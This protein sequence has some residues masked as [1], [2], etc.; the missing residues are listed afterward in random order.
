MNI[1]VVIFCFDRPEKLRRTLQT[2]EKNSNLNEYSFIAYQDGFKFPQVT[3]AY[4][5]VSEVWKQFVD[6]NELEFSA[7]HQATVNKGMR[8][9]IFE[10][11][12]STLKNF[13]AVIVLEDDLELHSEFLESMRFMLMTYSN[14]PQICHV[15]A[16][17]P[18]T[19]NL[20]GLNGLVKTQ[21]MFCWGW[22]TWSE[23]WMDFAKSEKFDVEIDLGFNTF[24]GDFLGLAGFRRQIRMNNAK[25][26][27][28]WAVY[29]YWYLF[30]KQKYCIGPARSMVRNTG[31]DGSG[32]HCSEN[33]LDDRFKIVFDGRIDFNSN[34]N[35][36][37]WHR[38]LLY[39]FDLYRW[40]IIRAILL[41]YK[42]IKKGILIK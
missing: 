11:V 36:P 16:W 40:L 21:M 8:N 42:K 41:I 6:R 12:T 34:K 10:G 26:I 28:T 27:K 23:K 37:V 20:Y 19:S 17:S 18:P 13:D 29:W 31:Y 24:I 39:L 33:D 25:L 14:E 5:M 4:R 7:F 15:N 22:G 9:S 30:R 2:L 38:N 32:E 3:E 1:A 35:K